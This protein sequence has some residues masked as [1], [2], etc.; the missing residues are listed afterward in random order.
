MHKIDIFGLPKTHF[1]MERNATQRNATDGTARPNALIPVIG[2]IGAM[3]VMLTPGCQKEKLADWAENNPTEVNVTPRVVAFIEQTA[4]GAYERDE[5][6]LS[7][8]SA[9]WYIEAALNYAY[10]NIAK[11]FGDQEVDTVSLSIPLVDGEVRGS[12]AGDAYQALGQVIN[13]ANIEGESHVALVDVVARNTGSSLDLDA[14]YVVRRGS[15][16][17]G[18]LNTTYGPNDHWGWWIDTFDPQYCNCLD[19]SIRGTCADK[20]IQSRINIAVNGGYYQYY[21]DVET[22]EVDHGA[23]DYPASKIIGLYNYPSPIGPDNPVSGDG[24]RDYP[25]Y[26]GMEACLDPDDMR[27]YTQGAWDLMEI[28]KS[29]YVPTKSFASCTIEGDLLYGA[30]TK[31]HWVKY[32]FGNIARTN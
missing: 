8:D 11:P 31:L 32:R 27:F 1:I 25:V 24:I 16:S 10:T 26:V 28:I 21:T 12:N 13:A 14:V 6:M 20:K 17:G 15:G 5:V 22:W 18:G 7:P 30:G 29:T 9:E 23:T 2:M 19:N 4:R 3:A